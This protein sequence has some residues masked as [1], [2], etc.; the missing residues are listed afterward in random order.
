MFDF[1]LYF[2]YYFL[3][4]NNKTLKPYLVSAFYKWSLDYNLTPLIEVAEC[5]YNQLPVHIKHQQLTVLNIHT[6]ATHD[7]KMEKEYISFEAVFN[8]ETFDVKITYESIQ[9]I[10]TKEEGYGLEFSVDTEKLKTPY[11]IS[12]N[13][14]TKKHLKLVKS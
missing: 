2:F 9:K 12:N 4:N 13:L 8:G 5:F 6:D 7:L 11:K 1:Y 3:M 14:K 10:F